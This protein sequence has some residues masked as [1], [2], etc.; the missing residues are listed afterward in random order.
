[1]KVWK[2]FLSVG[3]IVLVIGIVLFIAGLGMN[4][5]KIQVEYDMRTFN[6]QSD[7]TNLD[8]SL[9]AGKMN[10]VF[11]DGDKV[12]VEYPDAYQY[13]Y[14]VYEKNGCVYVEPKTTFFIWFGWNKIPDITVKIP[15]GKVMDL[16]VDLSA[17]SAN[18]RGGEFG[19]VRASLSAGKI[20]FDG[21]VVCNKFNASLS[22]GK[23]DAD[24]VDCTAFDLHLSAGM[25]LVDCVKCDD[26]SIDLSAGTASVTVLGSKS[27]YSISVDKSA[28]SCNVGGQHGAAIGKTI[29]IDLSAGSVSVEFASPD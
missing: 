2:I 5:W 7:N 10:I 29:D 24:R 3:I 18:I 19:N 4:G 20:N 13:G 16:K 11:H 21:T 17:G 14:K 8:L 25:A 28:G 6:A 23:L 1:M 26:I 9:S 12:E 27:D 15:D 22:A